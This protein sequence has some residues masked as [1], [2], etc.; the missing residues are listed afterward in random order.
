MIISKWTYSSA[1]YNSL[2]A[3]F[4]SLDQKPDFG[5][6]QESINLL[7]KGLEDILTRLCK[8]DLVAEEVF[9]SFPYTGFN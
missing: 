5:T 1:V 3:D 6:L 9:V 8:L 7:V 2:L 4:R